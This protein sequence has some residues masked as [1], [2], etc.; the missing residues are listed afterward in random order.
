MGH[1]SLIHVQLGVL[2]TGWAVEISSYGS[3][4]A[5]YLFMAVRK[6]ISVNLGV[7]IVKKVLITMQCELEDI[8][9]LG[10]F[11]NA[12]MYTELK[13]LMYVLF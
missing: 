3:S 10:Y 4:L 7:Q 6:V 8:G 5:Y 11:Q 13:W 2:E 12:K 1:C 9:Y